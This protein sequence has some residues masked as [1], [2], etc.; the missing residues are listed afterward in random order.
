MT[1]TKHVLIFPNTCRQL[2]NDSKH[3]IPALVFTI[4]LTTKVWSQIYLHK[5]PGIKDLSEKW[6]SHFTTNSDI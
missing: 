5:Q 6:C 1:A 4:F 3:E 2:K